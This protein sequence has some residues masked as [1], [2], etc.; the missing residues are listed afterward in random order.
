[1]EILSAIP[2]QARICHAQNRP[3]PSRKQ[4]ALIVK[5]VVLRLQFTEFRVENKK[6]F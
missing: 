3:I 1:M 4:T 6:L 5:Q 2:R